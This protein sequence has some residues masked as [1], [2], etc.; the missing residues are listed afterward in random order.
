MAFSF[1]TSSSLASSD[2][3]ILFTRGTSSWSSRSASFHTGLGITSTLTKQQQHRTSHSQA[4]TI[5]DIFQYRHQ[6]GRHE[7]IDGRPHRTT[8]FSPDL[9]TKQSKVWF[10][11]PGHP[12]VT[13][14]LP[15]NG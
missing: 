13:V 1:A 12:H 9:S 10:V 14:L 4:A 11:Q 7:I 15:Y 3:L 8:D 6:A 5:T 2:R